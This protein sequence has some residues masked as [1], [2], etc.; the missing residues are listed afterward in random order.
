MANDYGKTYSWATTVH[1][2]ALEHVQKILDER[3]FADFEEER[4]KG[5]YER[6]LNRTWDR[7]EQSV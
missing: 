7:F 6:A 5:A 1:G 3:A 4:K 2:R